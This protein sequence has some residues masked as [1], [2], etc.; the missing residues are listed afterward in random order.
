M[1]ESEDINILDIN[2]SNISKKDAEVFVETALSNN[3]KVK[4]YTP[5]PEIV[6]EAHKNSEFKKILNRGDL[7]LPDGTGLLFA[8]WLC[9]KNFKERITG[10]DFMMDI[11]VLAEKM[12]KSIFLLGG[13]DGTTQKT[14][15]KLKEI[16]PDIKIPGIS[17][18]IDSCYD[19]IRECE[20]D[21]IF[22]AL[23][24]PKQEEWVNEN[25]DKFP[26]IKIAMVVGGA[27]DII[28][29]KIPRAPKMMRNLGLEWLWRLI[30]EPRR[31]G[32]IVN[33]IIIFPIVVLK[34]RFFG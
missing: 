33:A 10:I 26:S 19:I 29:G 32:R 25:I 4:I 27:F 8:A 24:A 15:E 28:S 7:L 23:G 6:L 20:P 12:E 13:E 11:C 9:G 22:V 16:F 21:I 3:K 17:E 1:M 14:A 34:N 30:I 31:M 18:N 2:I 5:N